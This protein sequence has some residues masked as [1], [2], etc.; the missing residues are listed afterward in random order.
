MTVTNADAQS[1]ILTNGYNYKSG[2][3]GLGL[4]VPSGDPSSVT[5]TAGQS[6]TYILSIGGDGMGGTASLSCS[7]APAGATCSVPGSETLSATVPAN[8]NVSVTTTARTS[9]SLRF[10]GSAP[11]TWMWMFT[12]L[13]IVV[14][15]RAGTSKRSLRRYLKLAPLTLVL[16][17]ASCGG[18]SMGSSGGSSGPTP[19]PNGTPAGTYTLNVTATAAGGTAQTTSLTLIVK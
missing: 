16:L 15:P 11:A 14:L 7:G 6:A 17:L 19:N 13:G 18:G 1:G 9:G 5:V 10:P 3:T 12:M 8:F 4:V 2:A